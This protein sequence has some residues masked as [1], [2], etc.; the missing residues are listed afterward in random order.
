MPMDSEI[1]QYTIIVNG[2]T[3]QYVFSFDGVLLEDTG[4][5]KVFRKSFA[6]PLVS[7]STNVPTSANETNASFDKKT[8]LRFQKDKILAILY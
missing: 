8:I 2:A 1:K 7:V 6:R 4:D 5:E 3:S